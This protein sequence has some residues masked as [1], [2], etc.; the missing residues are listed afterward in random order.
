M[1][2]AFWTEFMKSSNQPQLVKLL[3][4]NQQDPLEPEIWFN[5]ILATQDK[6]SKIKLVTVQLLLTCYKFPT[7]KSFTKNLILTTQEWTLRMELWKSVKHLKVQVVCLKGSVK[8]K[9]NL[10]STFKFE[11]DQYKPAFTDPIKWKA[12]LTLL[13]KKQVH[14]MN[15]FIYSKH[16]L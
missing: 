12:G 7:L 16:S 10:C 8:N 14:P 11:I 9:K 3:I 6:R 13:H 15:L 1:L 4:M 2:S 5:W